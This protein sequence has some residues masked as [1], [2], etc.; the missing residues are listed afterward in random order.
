M[1]NNMSDFFVSSGGTILSSNDYITQQNNL[2]AQE[3]SLAKKKKEDWKNKTFQLWTLLKPKLIQDVLPKLESAV[4]GGQLI[5]H[6]SSNW[7][8]PHAAL[9][10]IT[11]L[12]KESRLYDLEMQNKI[13]DM[14]YP[15]RLK[16]DDMNEKSLLD[17]F[18]DKNSSVKKIDLDSSK[19][20]I[21]KYRIEESPVDIDE[22][23][24]SDFE[25]YIYELALS[26]GYD[27]KLTANSSDQGVD[28]ILNE[29]IAIQCKRYKD[30]VGNGAVQE[31][32]AGRRFY[33]CRQSVV[34]TNSKF[35]ENAKVLAKKNYV[36]LI[37]G[38]K[39]K[40]IIENKPTKAFG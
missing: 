5:S 40:E 39:L 16:F 26:L 14:F 2:L 3:N 28:I 12:K 17:A 36:K 29:S 38:E 19:D 15:L 37:D 31:V 6:W 11:S 10:K 8:A 32:V 20:K 25:K 34:I 23:S 30:N 35:T 22:L 33:N 18:L 4:R 7:I 27:A 21:S 24:G 9:E 1:I 13:D